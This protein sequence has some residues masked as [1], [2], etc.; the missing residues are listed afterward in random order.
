MSRVID[1]SSKLGEYMLKGWVL[2]DRACPKGCNVPL[3]RSPNGTAPIVHFCANCD[4]DPS[5]ISSGSSSTSTRPRVDRADPSSPSLASSTHYSRASTPPTEISSALS[6]PTFAPPM[7]TAET[8]RRRQQSD[9]ASIEIGKRLLKGWAML[10]DECPNAGCYGIPLVRP[11]K[12]GG[13]KDPRKECVACGTVYVDEKDA[14]GWDRLVPLDATIGRQQ[15][16]P[17][18]SSV[19]PSAGP[20]NELSSREDK[21]KGAVY[22]KTPQVPETLLLSPT[23]L[24]VQPTVFQS[25]LPPAQT[26]RSVPQPTRVAPSGPS[27]LQVSSHALETAL[28]ALSERLVRLSS[29]PDVVDPLS[30]GQTAEAISRVTQALSQV[31]HLQAGVPLRNAS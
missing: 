30:I 12:L 9:N 29:V 25:A 31:K 15:N 21:G 20:S 27:A 16:V 3:M 17:S 6:S 14:S 19:T 11:P 28:V 5:N 1:V 26:T 13:G 8:L 24:S 4:G 10:A 22:E 7:D 18:S 2:T 23:S